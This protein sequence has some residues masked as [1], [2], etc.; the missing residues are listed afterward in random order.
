MTSNNREAS[1]WAAMAGGAHAQIELETHER[2]NEDEHN[3]PHRE[4]V[5]KG[6]AESASDTENAKNS[7]ARAAI[8]AAEEEYQRAVSPE[9][10][11]EDDT[12]LDE[13]DD[14]IG[15]F[16]SFVKESPSCPG[17]Y[18]ESVQHLAGASDA[19]LG[20][21]EASTLSILSY[22]VGSLWGSCD[23]SPL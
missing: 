2:E 13:E 4:S 22:S 3:E 8:R 17:N 6:D 12:V 1:V 19:A 7:V 16:L 14:I 23:I 18:S 10:S 21:L 11:E 20:A 5:G 15:G 9:Y